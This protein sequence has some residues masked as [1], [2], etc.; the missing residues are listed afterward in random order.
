MAL[1]PAC[2]ALGS[3]RCAWPAAACTPCHPPT[4]PCQP[5]QLM[6][7]VRLLHSPDGVT[8]VTPTSFEDALGAA[9]SACALV[10][11]VGSASRRAEA[12]G[13]SGSAGAAAA[14]AGEGKQAGAGSP[15][16]VLGGLSAA[17]DEQ[18][19]EQGAGTLRGQQGACGSTAA[20]SL[21]RP[22]GHHATAD[23]PLGYCLFNNVALA[24][25]HAQRAHGLEKVSRPVLG[26]GG[27]MGG[28]AGAEWLRR[29]KGHELAHL[30]CKPAA[31]HRLAVS[32]HTHSPLHNISCFLSRS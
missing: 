15:T 19:V 31:C 29:E 9:G 3:R 16:T 17:A 1:H 6:L 21:C 4:R 18:Q 12:G 23:T 5:C 22:P 32:L 10:D 2:Q 20:V 26:F 24:A 28:L 30:L 11:A 14:G 8:Y 27:C 25:R 13:T 7:R